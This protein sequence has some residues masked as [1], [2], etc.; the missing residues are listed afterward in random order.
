V[1][2]VVV[3]QA[4]N[5]ASPRTRHR[6]ATVVYRHTIA[7]TL[8]FVPN[9]MVSYKQA[10]HKTACHIGALIPIPIPIPIARPSGLSSTVGL[11]CSARNH[12]MH[13]LLLLHSTLPLLSITAPSEHQA[14]YCCNRGTSELSGHQCIWLVRGHLGNATDL[15]ILAHRCNTRIRHRC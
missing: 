4:L 11:W 6:L 15:Y 14:L 7:P 12:C 3:H 10:P 8:E 13:L 1:L 5:V 9:P 2:L